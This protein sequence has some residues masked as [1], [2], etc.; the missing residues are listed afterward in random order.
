MFKVNHSLTTLL[1]NC[2]RVFLFIKNMEAAEFIQKHFKYPNDVFAYRYYQKE[3]YTCCDLML[4]Q[5]IEINNK[6]PNL[7]SLV[8]YVHL[9]SLVKILID[10]EGKV[11]YNYENHKVVNTPFLHIAKNYTELE[12]E[13]HQPNFKCPIEMSDF[14]MAFNMFLHNE[15]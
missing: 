14:T 11:V 2:S 4:I 3:K 15:Y 5:L 12:S 8:K 9:P 1:L 7:S 13:K 6:Y 10:N